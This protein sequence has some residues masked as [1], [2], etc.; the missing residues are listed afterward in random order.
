MSTYAGS[1]S[2]HCQEFQHTLILSHENYKYCLK[3]L[4]EENIKAEYP[5]A[6]LPEKKRVY[7]YT[8]I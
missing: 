5:L 8:Q 2:Q 3:Q 4:V 6:I 1:L 7:L